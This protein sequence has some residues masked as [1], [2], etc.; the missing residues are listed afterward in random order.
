[1]RKAKAPPDPTARPRIATGT[2]AGWD[3]SSAIV[4]SGRAPA[5]DPTRPVAAV[6][7]DGAPAD[8]RAF[9]FDEP[10]PVGALEAPATAVVAALQFVVPLYMMTIYNRILQTGSLETLQAVSLIAAGLLLVLG[11]AE[12]AFPV[13]TI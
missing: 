13:W 9:P 1:M 8:A 3:R 6:L 5:V 12:T 7:I 11:I 10:L 2:A 4:I